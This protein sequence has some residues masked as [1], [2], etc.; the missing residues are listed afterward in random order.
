[1]MLRDQEVL[2]S[3]AEQPKV[4][5][6]KISMFESPETPL[7]ELTTAS[8]GSDGT[9][10]SVQLCQVTLGATIGNTLVLIC[11]YKG[12]TPIVEFLAFILQATR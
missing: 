7:E 5:K 10:G 2:G 1:M 6:G 3:A 9:P 12:F 8:R 4:I 11:R